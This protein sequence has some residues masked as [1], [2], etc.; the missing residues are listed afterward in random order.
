MKPWGLLL[1]ACG[2]ASAQH[3]AYVAPIRPDPPNVADQQWV[4]NPIDQFILERLEKEGLRPSPEADKNTL[5][6]RVTLDLTGLP[7]TPAELQAFL[8]DNS[9]NA[10]EKVVDRLL[11][12]PHYGERMAMQWLDLARYADTHGYQLDSARE[13]WPWRDWV[14]DAFNRNMPFDRFTIEQLAGDLLPNATRDQKVATGFN[15]NNMI[16]SEGGSIPEEFLVEN[17]V[18]RV[19]TVSQVWLGTTLGCAR[20]HNHRYDPF[21]QRDFYRFFAYFN[22]IPENGV[23]GAA[24]NTV[25][26]IPLPTADQQRELERLSGA[27]DEREKKVAPAAVASL[28]AEW[29]KSKPAS[30]PPSPRAGL[31]AEYDLNGNFDDVSGQY[32]HG[33]VLSGEVQFG[34]GPV[35]QAVSLNGVSRVETGA[36]LPEG[37]FSIALWEQDNSRKQVSL[38]QNTEDANTRRGFEML[39]GEPHPMPEMNRGSFLT[40]R[41]VNRWPN[42]LIELRTRDRVT[43]NKWHHLVF[44]YDGSR[45]ASGVRVFLDGKPLDCEVTHDALSASPASARPLEIGNPELGTPYQGQL[46]DLRVYDRPLS[47]AEASVLA[48]HEPARAILFKPGSR[49][50][51]DEQDTLRRY[52]LTYDAPEPLRT[53]YSESLSLIAQRETLERRIPTVMVMQEMEKPRDTYILARGDYRNRTEK[54]TPGTPASLPP[55]PADAPP[56]RLGLA[57]WIVDPANP[58]TARVTVNRYWQLYFGTGLVKTTDNFGTQGEA[59]SHPQLLDWLATEFIRTGWDVKAMQKLIVT[60]AAYRQSSRVTPEL[61]EKDPENRL[62]ARGPRFRLPAE[63]IRDSALAA[64]GLLDDRIGGRS[65]FPYQPPG[66]WEELAAGDVYTAQAYVQ[67]HGRDLYRRGMYTFWKRTVPPPSLAAFDAPDR[68]KCTATRILT[69][70]PMQALVLM[71]DPAYVEAARV[72]AARAMKAPDPAV[73]LFQTVLARDPSADEKRVLADL[74]ARNLARFQQNPQASS[75]LLG[76]GEAPLDK[77]LD[78]AALAAW[79]TVSSVALNLD[80]AITKQ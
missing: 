74:A 57:R 15:R 1:L 76:V 48:L 10:Y 47:E 8:A 36:R 38:I 64:A 69:N 56:N 14:I 77:S 41:I 70:T 59:P 5:L 12:S 66:L 28:I 63:T 49:R 21:T 72:L 45:K 7:P 65:V 62:I 61:L 16:N 80:E 40:F 55:L 54:V 71:N 20:C 23:D 44:S 3:W 51:K 27:I 18:D 34:P 19:E 35:D 68:E 78:P 24:G 39:V 79:T 4:R 58:L 13:M 9:P 11:A 75:Q 60:S 33:R 37:A 43:Q 31:I 73:F 53:A 29:E 22:N 30:L 6:R 67:D 26:M 42:D 17:V 25:P 2:V 52:Y 46:D 50:T 32:R